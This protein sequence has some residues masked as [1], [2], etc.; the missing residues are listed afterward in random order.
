MEKKKYYVSLTTG[1]VSQIRYQNNDD[2]IIYATDAEARQLRNKFDSMDNA[3]LRSF[4]R[5][6]IPIVPYHHDQSNDDYDSAMEEALQMIYK[7][8]DDTTKENIHSMGVLDD[9]KL[10]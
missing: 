10:H 3:N 2:F 6:H 4:V 1:E 9:P 5:A 7:L 8:G